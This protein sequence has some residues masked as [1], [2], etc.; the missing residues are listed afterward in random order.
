MPDQPNF[1]VIMSDEHGPMWSGAYGHPFVRTPQHGAPGRSRRD[2]RRRVLQRASLRPVASVLPDGKIRLQLRGLGQREASSDRRSDL[3]L[4][5]AVDRLRQRAVGKDAPD[6]PGQPSRLP[7]ADRG[8]PE[9]GRPPRKGRLRRDA[10]APVGRRRPN[11]GRAVGQSARG[12]VRLQPSYRERRRNGDRRTR[13]PARPVAARPAVGAVRGIPSSPLPPHHAGAALLDVLPGAR[14]PSQQ[15]AGPPGG[16]ASCRQQAQAGIRILGL[17]GRRDTA[18]QGF[19][20][21]PSQLPGRQ[22]R[23]APGYTGRAGTGGGHRPSSTRPTTAS[24]LASTACGA[25]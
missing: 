11:G 22:D 4:R 14:R 9:A 7:R 3:A 25:R 15:S 20:L 23:P 8:G 2:L 21:W 10:D 19:L 12:G 18:C 5:A 1:L 6:W 16:P 17:Y 24:R 13:L